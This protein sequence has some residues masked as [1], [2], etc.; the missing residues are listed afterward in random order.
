[1]KKLTIIGAG[2]TGLSAGIHALEKGYSVDIYEKNN[3]VGGCCTGWYRNG[4]YIDNCMHWLT[5]TNQHTKLFKLWKHVHA[6][7]ETSNLYQ[8]E[9]FYKSILEGDS[10]SLY[11][12]LEKTRKEMLKLSIDDKTEINKFIN[13][14]K[15]LSES[16]KK[17]N[18]TFSLYLKGV[19]YLKAYKYYRN[20]SLFDLSNKFK[21]PLLKLLFTD[22]LPGTYCSLALIFAYSTF[23]SGNGK[24]YANG[25]KEF[26]ENIAKHFISLGG[27]IHLKH[28][29]KHINI[30]D[31]QVDSITFKDNSE[32]KVENL[33]YTADPYNLFNNLI[34]YDNIPDKLNTR[35][36]DINSYPPISSFHIA[37]LVDKSNLTFNDSIVINIPKIMIGNNNVT[38]ILL[39][40]YTFLYPKKPKTVIQV[41]IP[42]DIHDYHK[43]EELYND[44]DNY[45]NYKAKIVQSIKAEIIKQFPLLQDMEILDSWTPITYHSYYNSYYGSYMGFTFT[46]NSKYSF[47]PYKLKNIKNLLVGTY[48]QQICGGLPVGLQIGKEIVNKL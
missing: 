21:H 36:T 9:Y 14:V 15:I 20:L 34:P 19:G 33:I 17:H 12:D 35:F 5:G 10:I 42:Q 7:N 18:I 25:S 32:L 27:N 46:K 26:A 11:D 8:G 16:H 31:N 38:R 37:F 43:W 4:Y 1:M 41:F 30:I 2:I 39:K 6:M 44:K 3:W 28:E 24:I 47:I 45:N 22:Y 13:T 48:W 40:E 23:A 29:L